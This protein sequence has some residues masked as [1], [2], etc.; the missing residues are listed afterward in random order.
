MVIFAAGIADRAFPDRAD[1]YH[2]L[3][4]SLVPPQ[5]LP[6]AF[7]DLEREVRWYI[8]QAGRGIVG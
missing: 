3:A 7:H 8:K 2:L 6:W 1:S 5:S 4:K